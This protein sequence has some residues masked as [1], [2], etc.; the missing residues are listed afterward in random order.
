MEMRV[1]Y[2]LVGEEEEEVEEEEEEE[3][4][5]EVEE[6]V[7]VEEEEEEEEDVLGEAPPRS[8]R[9][10]PRLKMLCASAMRC[11]WSSCARKT[12]LLASRM[13][14]SVWR[15]NVRRPCQ[16]PGRAARGWKGCSRPCNG[17]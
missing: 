3:E 14:F 10:G 6:E 11:N 2:S 5:E 7:E 8:E 13:T 9:E 15:G 16:K 4:E 1:P 12:P 17:R